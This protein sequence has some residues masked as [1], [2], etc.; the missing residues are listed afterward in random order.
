MLTCSVADQRPAAPR[1][2]GQATATLLSH[3]ASPVTNQPFTSSHIHPPVP[4]CN[5]CNKSTIQVK[6]HRS[7][8]ATMQH[9][10]QINHSGQA[11][12]ILQSHNASPV[13]N[14]PFRSSHIHPP[15][16]QCITCN[17]STIQINPHRSTS[18]HNDSHVTNQPQFN[19]QTK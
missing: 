3:N 14:Q 13:T 5:T 2:S 6:P 9:L 12:P 4:Q 18:I 8:C 10:K 7:S 17:K 16:P 11:T 15:V 19:L 1:H